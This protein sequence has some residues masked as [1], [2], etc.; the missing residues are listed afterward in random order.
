[1]HWFWRET[2]SNL[3][4]SY[5]PI[6]KVKP[7]AFAWL[8]KS[9]TFC[10]FRNWNML[11]LAGALVWRNFWWIICKFRLSARTDVF[12]QLINWQEMFT[13][14]FLANFHVSHHHLIE[15]QDEK[16]FAQTGYSLFPNRTIIANH[17]WPRKQSESCS[18]LRKSN[19]DDS[20]SLH[21]LSNG[22]A[23]LDNWSPRYLY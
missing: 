7:Q 12:M 3:A 11:W 23:T 6:D 22:T 9:L 14:T 10:H 15:K 5:N 8:E 4:P 21:F 18:L 17:K 19:N 2:K 16:V 1:M 20:P 13:R